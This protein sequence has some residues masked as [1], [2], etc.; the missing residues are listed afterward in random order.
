MHDPLTQNSRARES[1]AFIIAQRLIIGSAVRAASKALTS[2]PKFKVSSLSSR[3]GS[4]EPWRRIRSRSTECW[5]ARADASDVRGP[6]DEQAAGRATA[7]QGGLGY[8]AL[9]ALDAQMLERE[10]TKLKLAAGMQ[11]VAEINQGERS[12]IEYLLSPVQ[13]TAGEAGRER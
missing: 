1:N 6:Q 11:V 3:S 5:R 4:G 12:V 13:K 2:V 7:R 10:S 8:R 9:V